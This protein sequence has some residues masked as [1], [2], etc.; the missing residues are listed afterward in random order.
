MASL[1]LA[2]NG[3]M[4]EQNKS[5]SLLASGST[6]AVYTHIYIAIQYVHDAITL[7]CIRMQI[8]LKFIQ[9]CH[10]THSLTYTHTHTQY[11]YTCTLYMFD[12]IY[13]YTSKAIF[14]T[15]MHFLFIF[16]TF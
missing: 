14:N 13:M 12:N 10:H 5:H 6:K 4:H 2:N 3:K 11:M 1:S 15:Q 16:I 7:S 8:G 9:S